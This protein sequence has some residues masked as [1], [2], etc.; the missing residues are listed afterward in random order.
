MS[1]LLDFLNS[2][3]KNKTQVLIA[4]LVSQ[5]KSNREIEQTLGITKR[6]VQLN[7]QHIYKHLEIKTRI[8]LMVKCSQNTDEKE[9]V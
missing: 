7:L 4:M 9:A 1:D 8:H 5:G 3:M 6:A 2:K